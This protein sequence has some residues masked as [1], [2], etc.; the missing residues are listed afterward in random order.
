[1]TLVMGRVALSLCMA[2][3]CFCFSL[4]KEYVMKF[5]LDVVNLRVLFNHFCLMY[6][7]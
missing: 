2:L 3:K 6:N 7:V 4:L 1:M 5:C